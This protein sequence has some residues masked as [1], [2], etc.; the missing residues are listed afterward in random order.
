MEIEPSVTWYGE[1]YGTAWYGNGAH[2][3]RD[4]G[5]WG[6]QAGTRKG[7]SNNSWGEAETAPT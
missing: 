3:H 6:R 1:W 4:E 2:F 5:T 7:D